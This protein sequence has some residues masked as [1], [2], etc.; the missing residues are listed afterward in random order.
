MFNCQHDTADTV[1][2]LLNST[3]LSHLEEQFN[4][5]IHPLPYGA[6]LHQLK[7]PSNLEY[8]MTTVV[9]LALFLDGS[10]P[11]MTNPVYLILQGIILYSLLKV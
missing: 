2:W 10:R 8:N 4:T 9:C 11:E 5:C 6:P 7:I 1:G 3:S